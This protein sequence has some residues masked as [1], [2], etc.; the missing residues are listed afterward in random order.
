MPPVVVSTEVSRPAEDVFAYATDPSRFHEWQQGL[1][2]GHLE[3]TGE[4]SVGDRCRMV[5]RIGFADRAS[6]SEVVHIDPPRSWQTR[7]IDGPIRAI[8]QV[9]VAPLAADR[10][11]LTISLDFE[12]HGVGA[13]LVPLVVRRQ[14]RKEMP[15]NL[16][17]LKGRLESGGRQRSTDTHAT[18]DGWR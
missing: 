16:A 1:I 10:A 6:T 12:G 5:R 7:G 17:T 15:A 18:G 14:A 11:R 2:S 3:A 4:A 13:L 9:T 8:V